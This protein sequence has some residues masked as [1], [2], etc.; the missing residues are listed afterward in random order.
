MKELEIP[1]PEAGTPV[2]DPNKARIEITDNGP[3]L[4]YG[5]PPINTYTI[6]YDEEGN[7]WGYEIGQKDYCSKD[8]PSTLCRCGRTKNAPYCDGSHV[9][10]NKNREW[11]S[12][13]TAPFHPALDSAYLYEGE[14]IMLTD[15]EELCAFARFCDAKG[16]TW[17]QVERS[18]EPEQE[19]LAIRTASAC[20]AGRLKIWKRD[21]SSEDGVSDSIEPKYRLGIGLIEDPKIGVSGPLFAMGGIPIIAANRRAYEPRNRV[22]LCRCGESR[23]KPFC[24]GTHA[25]AHFRDRLSGE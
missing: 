22:T 7:S 23:N 15:V 6:T 13:L 24:D 19:Q 17:T 8:E 20:P 12:R 18:N 4:I 5:R 25:P 11:D 21:R 9:K 1:T 14:N 10:A 2:V 3:Y 16:R